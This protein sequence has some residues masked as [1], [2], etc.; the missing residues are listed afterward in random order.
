M[1]TRKTLL[2]ISTAVCLSA[3]L[4]RQLL[5]GNSCS[6]IC[7]SQVFKRSLASGDNGAQKTCGAMASANPCRD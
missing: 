7:K 2:K 6:L 3:S 1:R 4:H 5:S